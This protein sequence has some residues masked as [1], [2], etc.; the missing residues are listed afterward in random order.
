MLIYLKHATKLANPLACTLACGMGSVRTE[1]FHAI[2]IISVCDYSLPNRLLASL[3]WLAI[4]QLT[5]LMSQKIY[6][7]VRNYTTMTL[8]R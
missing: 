6:I 1:L 5:F 2:I 8:C 4:K 3:L 7:L